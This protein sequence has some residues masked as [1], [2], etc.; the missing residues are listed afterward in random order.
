MSHSQG[1]FKNFSKTVELPQ[2]TLR[3]DMDHDDINR[4]TSEILNDDREPNSNVDV[5]S[6]SLFHSRNAMKLSELPG[7]GFKDCSSLPSSG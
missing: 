6:S 7:I 1:S 2:E 5:L 3:L 4:D